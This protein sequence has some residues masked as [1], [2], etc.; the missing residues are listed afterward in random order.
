MLTA[1]Y[2][3]LEFCSGLIVA[4]DLFQRLAHSF[5]VSGLSKLPSISPK[6]LLL[7]NPL[8]EHAPGHTGQIIL[9]DA[10]LML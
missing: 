6:H 8:E 4:E 3:D 5:L 2:H 7:G 9:G 10:S 1:R